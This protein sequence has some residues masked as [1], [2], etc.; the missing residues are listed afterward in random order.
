MQE[1]IAR[2]A[3]DGD[4]PSLPAPELPDWCLEE[5]EANS[6]GEEDSREENGRGARPKRREFTNEV[7]QPS[8]VSWLI[9][10]WFTTAGT[11]C[12]QYSWCER[13][14]VTT[15][16]GCATNLST[17]AGL[18]EVRLSRFTVDIVH[19]VTEII[20][21]QLVSHSSG[22]PGSQPVSM[23]VQNI[24][25]LHERP[26]RVSW[27]ADGTRLEHTPIFYH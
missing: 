9:S 19:E 1:L 4:V 20:F 21:S 27:K 3:S 17:D 25:L 26:Y 12:C 15:E 23:D 2:Y 13:G 10:H 11:V 22:F 8:L 6:G 14:A 7:R 24:K 16:G 18:G 5:E